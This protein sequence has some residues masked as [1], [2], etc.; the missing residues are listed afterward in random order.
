MPLNPFGPGSEEPTEGRIDQLSEYAAYARI[1]AAR[2]ARRRNSAYRIGLGIALVYFVVVYLVPSALNFSSMVTQASHNSHRFLQESRRFIAQQPNLSG[3]VQNEH[4]LRATEHK[5]S[6]VDLESMMRR[7][8]QFAG[9]AQ[10]HC[11]PAVRDWD[12]VCSYLPTPQQSKTRMQ[13]GIAVDST[14][15]VGFSYVVPMGT[16]IPQRQ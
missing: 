16:A 10:L 1:E 9:R 11:T 8:P 5:L 6:A 4:K 12:Y 2:A 13:F 3:A 15:W 7:Q 14:Q